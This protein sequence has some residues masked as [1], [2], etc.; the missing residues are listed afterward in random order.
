MERRTLSPEDM[1]K[2]EAMVAT[3]P[4]LDNAFRLM[5]DGHVLFENERY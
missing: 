4:V 5:S 2:L 3:H 1:Q